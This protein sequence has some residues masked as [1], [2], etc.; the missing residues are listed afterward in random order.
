MNWSGV[1]G[2]P[3]KTRESGTP[4]VMDLPAFDGYGDPKKLDVISRIAEQGGRDPQLA[5]IAVNI[6]RECNVAPRDYRGQAA[7][8]LKWVQRNIYYVNE[9]DE[10]LQ[11]PFYTLK[12]KYGDCDDMAILVY[13]LARSVRLPARLVISGVTKSGKKVRYR[14]G[15]PSFDRSVAWSHIYLMI[16]DRPYGQPEW[17]YA[18]PTLNVPFGWDVV[19]HKGDILPEMTTTSSY[20][21]PMPTFDPTLPRRTSLM[22]PALPSYPAIP[23]FSPSV[24]SYAPS[25][26]IPT[27]SP[28]A[29]APSAYP[30]A[31]GGY[32]ADT[33]APSVPGTYAPSTSGGYFANTFAPTVPGTS[34]SGGYFDIA[35]SFT[36]PGTSGSGSGD[37]TLVP[38]LYTQQAG[39]GDY[40]VIPEGQSSEAPSYQQGGDSNGRANAV[41]ILLVDR[42]G[43]IL[44][45]H[46]APDQAFMGGSWDL[47]GGK[48]DPR[49]SARD[50]AVRILLAEAGIKL[51]AAALRPLLT[52]Y[53][54][55]AGTSMFFVAS[56]PGDAARTIRVSAP[57]HVAY[58]WVTPEEGR[59]DMQLVPYMPLVLRALYNAR[60][61]TSGYGAPEDGVRDATFGLGVVIAALA[62]GYA[63]GT[64]QL[65]NAR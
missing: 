41:A 15:D 44:L 63:F 50:Q 5:T 34:G 36:A 3:V 12:V 19:A 62:A 47:P 43:Q 25:A 8:I 49:G 17:T 27:Y 13:A 29:P 35:P 31:S 22:A 52:A 54:P 4:K 10:R 42:G 18:E 56:V 11:D 51:P 39:S 40:R 48:V 45:L 64:W 7:A 33:F 20:G 6:F 24:P 65:R 55:S 14:Q 38:L 60:R 59:A 32:F 46:R 26:T 61:G 23:T 30:S 37:S 28:T 16:G 9:P 57:E 58:R 1:L 21:S 2:T 53:H